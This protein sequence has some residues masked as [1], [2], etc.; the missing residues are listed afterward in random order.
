MSVP[1]V[2]ILRREA[3][4]R[5][6]A[7]LNPRK[8]GESEKG[9]YIVCAMQRFLT[10]DAAE[11]RFVAVKCFKCQAEITIDSGQGPQTKFEKFP[12][13]CPICNEPFPDLLPTAVKDYR[14]SLS[15]F[16][17]K[18]E[19]MPSVSFRVLVSPDPAV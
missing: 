3:E 7:D 10:L 11:L 2:E 13:R 12:E 6:Q 19:K 9:E 1:R 5:K 4:Y 8:C 16:L 17:I 18:G 14:S 15:Y